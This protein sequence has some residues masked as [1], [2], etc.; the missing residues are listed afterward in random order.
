[1]TTTQDLIDRVRRDYLTQGRVEPRNKLASSVD[2]ST[3]TFVMAYA[4]DNIASGSLLSIG[5]EDCYVWSTD[6]TSKTITVDRGV[7]GSTAAT[8]TT[9]ERVRVTARWTDSQ[10]LRAINSELANLYAQ[11]LYQIASTEF[12]FTS[13][14]VGYELPAAALGVWRVWTRDYAFK[15][16][17]KV[18]GWEVD[19]SAD[20]DVFASGVALYLRNGAY[21]GR[22][23]RVQYRAAFTELTT[24]S[25]NVVTATGLPATAVDVL[26]MGT[27]VNVLVGR[28]VAQRLLE[29]Q[30]STRR[31]EE[32]P[33]GALAQSFTPI[34][35]NYQARVRAERAALVRQ[36]G[37]T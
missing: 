8:H 7:D 22:T 26:A 16:W 18:D 20:P 14:N 27:A 1:M 21:E 35:R 33:P 9:T 37:A 34:I 5:L 2:A 17:V 4:L 6:D 24:L 19:H 23:V 11:G 32:V 29:S 10:I 28:E 31:A 13:A 36:Y 3:D 15:N 25:Q 30:G 12:T